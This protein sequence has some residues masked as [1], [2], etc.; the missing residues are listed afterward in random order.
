MSPR[1]RKLRYARRPAGDSPQTMNRCDDRAPDPSD[2]IQIRRPNRDCAVYSVHRALPRNA[3]ACGGA[4]DCGA[5]A[6]RR[7]AFPQLDVVARRADERRS[8]SGSAFA[9]TGVPESWLQALLA[10]AILAVA[11]LWGHSTWNPIAEVA[12]N[13]A[14][15]LVLASA[16]WRNFREV[17]RLHRHGAVPLP[18]SR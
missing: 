17:R 4:A 7:C 9:C 1:E 8:D 18:T 15:S 2:P 10:V 14:A 5:L 11:A 16:H 12:V 6:R 13:V 3:A